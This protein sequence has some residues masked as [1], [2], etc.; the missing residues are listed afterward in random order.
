MSL[1]YVDA[2]SGIAGDM[3]I[4]GL[5]D[6]GA[7]FKKLEAELAKLNLEG[8]KISVKKEVKNGVTGKKFDVDFEEDHHHRGLTAIKEIINNSELSEKVKEQ[9][10]KVFTVL[11][12]AEAKVHDSTLEE[13]HFHEVG[14]IDAIID[15]VGSCIC[16]EQLDWPE[17]V[18]SAV[19]VGTGFVR[20]AHGIIP[21]PAPATLEIL[22]K[23][24]VPTYSRGIKNELTTPT[25]AALIVA[26][27]EGYGH[28]PEMTIDVVGYGAGTRNLN[29]PNFTR[30]L[31]GER[32]KNNFQKHTHHHHHGDE[33]GHSHSH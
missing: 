18:V 13:V 19:H 1:L 7:S 31:L 4:G 21:V 32:K 12:E 30:L 15:I 8:Y 23:K 3:F 28:Q 14:A 2:Y 10:I 29:I 17:I 33:N 11:A 16:L 27:G 26:L 20:A 5:L 9:S 6:I 22:T 25:G 24:D